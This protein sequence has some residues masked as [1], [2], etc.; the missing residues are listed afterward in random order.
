MKFDLDLSRSRSTY[1]I[2][3]QTNLIGPL[4]LLLHTKAKGDQP[5]GSG[6]DFLKRFYHIWG[7]V[8]IDHIWGMVA[9]FVM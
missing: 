8:A 1:K 4:S 9:I 3:I 2:F 5:S 7:M 6:E